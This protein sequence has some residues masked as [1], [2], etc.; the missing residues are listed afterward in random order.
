MFE[1]FQRYLIKNSRQQ[2]KYIPYYLKWISDC[3]SFNNEPVDHNLNSE[4]KQQFLTHLAKNREDWQVKQ[5]DYALR[6]YNFF[7]SR[8]KKET[9]ASKEWKIIEENT[10]KALRLRHR[11]LS[12]EKSYIMWLRQF[13]GFIGTKNPKN[14]QE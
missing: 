2:D 6:L 5:A 14:W 10:T 1:E 4:Q 9:S 11:S 8:N 12:T 7:L 3:Y 13:R